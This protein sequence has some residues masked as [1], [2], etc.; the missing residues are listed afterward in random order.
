MINELI[1]I[2]RLLRVSGV[3]VALVWAVSAL[4]SGERGGD[5]TAGPSGAMREP[6]STLP[7]GR[8]KA[9]AQSV[10]GSKRLYVATEIGLF[11]SDDKGYHWDRLRFAPLRNGDVLTLAIHPLHEGHLFIGGRGGLWKSLDGGGSWKSLSTPTGTRSAIRSIAVAPTAP[12]TIYIGTDQEGVFRSPDGG[13]FWSPAGQGLPEALAGGR[14]API[15]SLAIDP[16]NASI[17]YASTELHGLYKTTDGG[18]S[19]AAVNQ[20]LGLFPLPWRAGSPSIVISHVDPRQMMAMLP[21]PLHS[22]LV[23]T[24]VYQ[25]SDGGK[26]WFAL[27]VEVPPD[28]QGVTLAEDPADPKHVMLLTTKGAIQ[29][30]WQPIAG[31][32]N[33][34]P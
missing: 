30:Q 13:S 27:E 17:A 21:R 24:F 33:T 34:G 25:S 7:L 18:T 15:R 14:V 20:G 3:I 26:H 9:M 5:L 12:E 22:R 29:I 28:T 23:K 8:P 32:G 1:M 31:T 10:S 6:G 2:S 16:T 4:A 11:T 19:W